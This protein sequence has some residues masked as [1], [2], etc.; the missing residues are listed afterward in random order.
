MRLKKP[1]VSVLVPSYNRH[2]LLVDTLK[3]LLIQKY[4]PNE[5]IVYDQSTN[6]PHDVEAFLKQCSSQ[7]IHIKGHP[8]GLVDAYRRCVELSHGDICL[9]VDDDVLISDPNMVKKHVD[10]YKDS[11][12]GA[13]SGQVLHEGQVD[14]R[15]IDPRVRGPNGWMFVRFDTDTRI[16]DLPSLFGPNMSFRKSVY[17]RIGGFDLAYSGSG[18]RFETDFTFAVK[19][20]GYKVIFDPTASIVHRY[21]Q[22]G[23]AENRHLFS[24]KDDSHFWYINF[25]AN[26]WYFLKKW[27][28]I[29][30]AS[31]LMVPIWREHVINRN[32]LGAGSKFLIKRHHVFLKG[33][34]L[35]QQRAINR[36]SKQHG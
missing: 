7:T 5:I 1:H 26:T 21:Q 6:H 24:L 35:G 23:G 3:G 19:A 8:K 29:P 28:S 16:E 20:A 36:S 34:F 30:V 27:Y 13:V 9:F 4:K 14:A 11:R 31:K 32:T 15:P 10:N 2:E 25:F 18:F 22:P 17:E 33:I 12:I